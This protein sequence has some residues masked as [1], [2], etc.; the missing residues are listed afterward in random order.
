MYDTAPVSASQERVLVS[1]FVRT[2][3]FPTF[4]IVHPGCPTV[5][6]ILSEL[7]FWRSDPS[8]FVAKILKVYSFGGSLSIYQLYTPPVHWI[9]DASNV[10]ASDERLSG[11]SPYAILNFPSSRGVFSRENWKRT[12]VPSVVIFTFLKLA[13]GAAAFSFTIRLT[14]LLL[15]V[16]FPSELFAVT[17]I[18]YVP[19]FAGATVSALY[20]PGDFSV[21]FMAD[22]SSVKVTSVSHASASVSILRSSPVVTLVGLTVVVRICGP[23]LLIPNLVSVVPIILLFPSKTD[24]ERIFED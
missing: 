12:F 19:G 13:E 1:L 7:R 3:I 16:D 14:A 20:F 6:L 11:D 10:I 9:F 15:L 23:S 8:V 24:A 5:A 2:F 21:A 22:P 4:P 18:G 17:P